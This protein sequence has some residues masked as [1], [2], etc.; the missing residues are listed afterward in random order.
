MA[1]H[2]KSKKSSQE[3]DSVYFLKLVLYFIVGTFWIHIG[4]LS[5]IVPLPIGGV[6]GLWFASHE[7]FQIDRK[8]E[9]A[10]L[11]VAVVISYFFTPRFLV[12]F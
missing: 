8:I 1:K 4:T 11:L 10:V 9:Y 5:T 6:L 3:L 12:L 2:K 7:H